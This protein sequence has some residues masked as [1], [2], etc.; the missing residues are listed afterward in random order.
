MEIEEGYNLILSGRFEE[1]KNVLKKY[2]SGKFSD[3]WPLWYYL[4]TADLALGLAEEAAEEFKKVLTLSPSNREA[5]EELTMIYQSLGNEEMAE[6]YRKK[7]KIV[8]ENAE[9]DREE[10]ASGR[11]EKLN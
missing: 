1:G 2:K 5:M 3:W 8:A 7:I 4:G 11:P 10:A 6:K 9:K